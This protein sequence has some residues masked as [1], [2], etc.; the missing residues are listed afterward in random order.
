MIRWGNFKPDGLFCYD[1]GNTLSGA[2]TIM[3]VPLFQPFSVLC[4]ALICLTA[5]L[6]DVQQK[7]ALNR[8]HCST[9]FLAT[10]FFSSVSIQQQIV[11]AVTVLLFLKRTAI[12]HLYKVVQL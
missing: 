11:L 3:Y 10:P 1:I 7:Y 2:K 6:S 5:S 12:L 9:R 4:L 8:Q